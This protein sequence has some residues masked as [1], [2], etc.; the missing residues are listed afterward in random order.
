[1]QSHSSASADSAITVL[2][3]V[4]NAGPFLD[5][6]VE[7]IE[8][9]TLRAVRV[10]AIDDGSTDGSGERLQSRTSPTLSVIRL[11]RN[12]GLVHAL[13]TGLE[14]VE[15]PFLARMD[16]DDISIPERLGLQLRHLAEN[17]DVVLVGTAAAHI[18]ASSDEPAWPIRMPVA[19]DEI[20][21]AMSARRS[22]V[23]HPT[24]MARTEAIRAAGGYRAEAYPAEDYDLFLRLSRQG[25]LANLASI[26]YLIRL[27]PG[28]ITASNIL[29]AQRQYDRIRRDFTGDQNSPKITIRDLLDMYS[30]VAYR[31]G[32]TAAVNGKRLRGS[33]WLVSAAALS[34]SRTFEY[35][36]RRVRLVRDT[37][38]G[39]KADKA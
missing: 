15:T 19:H 3:P 26:L 24:I 6:A 35:V 21:T 1:V 5:A 37:A 11:P 10:I 22:A 2:L 4:F 38:I 16:A 31:R 34:P 12:R 13:N 9:Q 23:I 33:A 36:R 14:A 25:R 39:P 8:T 7:S 28:S 20:M 18:G 29:R 30:V 32:I 27:H 17:P